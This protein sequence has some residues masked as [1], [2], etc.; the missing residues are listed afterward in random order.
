MN[1]SIISQNK[2]TLIA[3]AM[4]YIPSLGRK[5]KYYPDMDKQQIIDEISNY[6]KL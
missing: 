5:T 3:F 4:Q 6:Q 1:L 2:G